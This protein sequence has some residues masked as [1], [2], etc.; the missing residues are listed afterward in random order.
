MLCL[1]KDIPGLRSANLRKCLDCLHKFAEGFGSF[2][3]MSVVIPQMNGN[4]FFITLHVFMFSA[5][6]WS[7]CGVSSNSLK[8]FFKA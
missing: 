5:I 7:P 3:D 8:K 4:K 6:L 1:A 2:L